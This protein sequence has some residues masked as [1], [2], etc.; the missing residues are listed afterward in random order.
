MICGRLTYPEYD[1]VKERS[2][3]ALLT[4]GNG[5]FG[6]RGAVEELDANPVNYPGT[7]MAGLY[8]RLESKVA[9]HIVENEDFVNAPNWL[10]MTF[11]INSENWFNPNKTE[12]IS[13]DRKLDF[14][15]GVLGRK[16]IV[17]DDD[18]RKTLIESR[19]MSVWPAGIMLQWSIK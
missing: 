7:Y 17:E 10:L 8:N 5:Y 15:T 19:R 3:E 18:G 1:P 11:K 6:T 9:E 2:R 13:F 14:R 4:T 12:I 16:M